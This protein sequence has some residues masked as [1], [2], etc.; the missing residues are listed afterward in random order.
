MPCMTGKDMGSNDSLLRL[1]LAGQSVRGALLQATGLVRAMRI[2]HGLGVLESLVL[3]HAC[4]AT[5]LI[6][7]SLKTGKERVS[8]QVECSGPIRG[9]VAEANGNGEVRGYLKQVP[10]PVTGPLDSFDLSPFFGAGFL[11]VSRYAGDG[12]QPFTGQ[13]ML[14][15]GNLA[16]DLSNYFL[17]SEQLPTALTLSV[18]F[19]RQGEV[20]GAGGLLLQAMPGASTE[21]M[22]EL[23][24]RLAVFP[25]LGTYLQGG[26][27]MESLL[28][29]QLAGF[30]PEV[31]DETAVAF[32]CPCNRE[33]ME[34]MLLTLPGPDLDDLRS[35]G[36]FPLAIRCHFCGTFHS[37]EQSAL[38]RL[39]QE[40]QTE[41]V[42]SAGR[43]S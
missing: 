30:A 31:L 34:A 40:R 39:W 4:M 28:A 33:R 38:E 11:S 6:A 7:S 3:G 15:H 17:L 41:A 1:L 12:G 13:V 8:L 23:E 14:E 43:R 25:S 18:Q 29:E 10:I 35:N 21:L 36:P 32:R 26:G 19:D 2:A 5:L 22:A 20:T 24:Q 16:Q 9:L 27:T 37:F 42:I